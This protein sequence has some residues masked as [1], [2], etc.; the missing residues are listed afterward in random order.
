MAD[1][2]AVG[3][4]GEAIAEKYL[5]KNG[6]TI[7][8]K[9]YRTRYGEIDLIIKKKSQIRFIEVKTR[10][11]IVKGQPYEAVN[12]Y[13]IRHLQKAAEYFLLQKKL[14]N[15]KLSLDVVSIV[16]KKDLQIEKIVFLENINI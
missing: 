8:A 15:Y 12:Y 5:L 9:N 10:I 6:Y 7:I 14:K 4:K 2:Q 16:L 11:G 1:N 3:K 13:K